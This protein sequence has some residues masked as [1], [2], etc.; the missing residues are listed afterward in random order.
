VKLQSRRDGKRGKTILGNEC[1]KLFP[2]ELE[3]IWFE[4]VLEKVLRNSVLD[5][6]LFK[7]MDGRHITNVVPLKYM[8]D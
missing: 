7:D 4:K 3:Q 5:C 6:D 8:L 2:L 1:K